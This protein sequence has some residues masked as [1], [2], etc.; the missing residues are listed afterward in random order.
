MYIVLAGST[1][2]GFV[3]YGPFDDHIAAEKWAKEN[4]AVSY[5]VMLVLPVNQLWFEHD[6]NPSQVEMG[7]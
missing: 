6:K 4:L 2:N 3:P 7:G 1:A 5:D